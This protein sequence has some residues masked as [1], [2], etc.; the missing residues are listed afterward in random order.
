MDYINPY[1]FGG[2]IILC[3][4][5]GGT[6]GNLGDEVGGVRYWNSDRSYEPPWKGHSNIHHD[7]SQ[8]ITLQPNEEGGYPVGM[9]GYAARIE[10]SQGACSVRYYVKAGAGRHWAWYRDIGGGGNYDAD[11]S[12]IADAVPGADFVAKTGWLHWAD[13]ETGI[14]HFSVR[15]YPETD[16]YLQ[17]Y[18]KRL[19][20]ILD[21]PSGCGLIACMRRD[22]QASE[23]GQGGI[24]MTGL[25]YYQ[26]RSIDKVDTSNPSFSIPSGSW[27]PYGVDKCGLHTHP[28]GDP[29][30]DLDFV[31]PANK[32]GPKTGFL[33]PYAPRLEMTLMIEGEADEF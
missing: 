11:S 19:C 4:A 33:F 1:V 23:C 17:G 12:D 14:K 30:L 25:Q 8:R 32:G 7:S 5:S 29:V 20:V 26:M 18:N 9:S 6:N 2:N 10:G 16:V 21:Q 22:S 13:G 24:G 27:P 15:A 28:F 31:A 3:I